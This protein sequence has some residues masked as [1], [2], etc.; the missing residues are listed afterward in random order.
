MQGFL[1]YECAFLGFEIVMGTVEGFVA[2]VIA[3]RIRLIASDGT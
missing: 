2:A 1:V 3:V